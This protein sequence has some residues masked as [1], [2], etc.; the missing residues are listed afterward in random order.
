MTNDDATDTRIRDV[1]ICGGGTAGWIAA[2][3][4]AKLLPAHVRIRLIESDEIGTVGVGEATIPQIRR[5]NAVLGIDEDAFVRE[6]KGTFKLG[7][8][9]A[10]WGGQGERYLHTFGD[11]GV[12]VAGLGFHHYWLRA[13]AE[14]LVPDDAL[15]YWDYSLHQAAANKGRFGR[16]E[17]VGNTS[18]TGLAY[19][20]HFDA[21]LYAKLLRTYAEGRGV[22]RT[23]GRI[24]DVTLRGADGHVESVRLADGQVIAGD[25][26]VDCSG[27]RG[28]LI[29]DA[30]EV[31][32]D[33]W[34][35][36]LPANGAWAVPCARTDPLLPYTRATAHEAGWQ[37]RIPLQHRTGNG[38]VFAEGFTD[39]GAA[40]DRLLGNLDAEP[41]AEPRRLRFTTGRRRRFWERNVVALGLSAGFLEPLESTS[42]HLIQSGVNRLIE[43]FP[44]KRF[45]ASLLAEYER[46]QGQEFA[47][48]RDFLV[49]H[50]KQ[51]RRRDTPFWRHCAE[52]AVPDSLAA[53]M[54]L[55]ARGARLYR[56]PDDLFREA[57]WVQ[58]MMGQGLMPEGYHPMADR[59]SAE[60]LTGM[61]ADVRRIVGQATD[62]LPGHADFVGRL[63]G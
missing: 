52:M 24:A 59:L 61:L 51:T 32:Y 48:I 53:K 41:L 36:W 12:G 19:A 60:Q 34:S 5:L 21:G 30:L 33:D 38:H 25:L 44:D 4:M 46:Q 43:L 23:E 28:L 2:A 47:L 45:D 56:E 63:A 1:V 31:G 40:L 11:V 7:I 26:F 6:T 15:G 3:A 20:F 35:E 42:I 49:L 58:V 55:F 57:S 8:E 37:W 10:N 54:A 39:E 62:R 9:F 27:F 17:R 14:G 50:Y 29:G 13:R 16:M 18:M 22:A